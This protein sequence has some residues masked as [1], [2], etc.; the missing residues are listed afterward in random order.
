MYYTNPE[1]FEVSEKILT[2]T[3]NSIQSLT[4]RKYAKG[5]FSSIVENYNVN[6][7]QEAESNI[8]DSINTIKNA[9]TRAPEPIVVTASDIKKK[10]GVTL[11]EDFGV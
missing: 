2:D 3:A 4:I 11:N 6:V 9:D 8:E 1:Q 7:Q 10:V 5:D